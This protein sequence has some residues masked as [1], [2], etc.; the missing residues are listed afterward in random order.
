MCVHVS[1]SSA[2]SYRPIASC[3]RVVRPLPKVA[4]RGAQCWSVHVKHR[5]KKFAFIFSCQDGLLWHFVLCTGSFRYMW[6][7]WL[8]HSQCGK[9][10]ERAAALVHCHHHSNSILWSILACVRWCVFSPVSILCVLVS[11][12]TSEYRVSSCVNQDW[13]MHGKLMVSRPTAL[14]WLSA[15]P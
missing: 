3:F 8:P 9:K 12:L 1:E 11:S 15:M 10:C 6:V 7:L 4:H 2:C 13:W 5:K 14:R